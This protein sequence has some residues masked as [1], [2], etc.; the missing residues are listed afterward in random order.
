[1]VVGGWGGWGTGWRSVAWP[2]AFH[3]LF[4]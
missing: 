4:T 2:A 3:T 1:V